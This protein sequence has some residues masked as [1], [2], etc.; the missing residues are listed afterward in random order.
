[1]VEVEPT[2]LYARLDLQALRLGLS[3]SGSPLEI[4]GVSFRLRECVIVGP[5][6]AHRAGRVSPATNVRVNRARITSESQEKLAKAGMADSKDL[7]AQLNRLQRG[8]T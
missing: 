5:R 2:G 4:H 6:P 1:M 3:R 8:G 7:T